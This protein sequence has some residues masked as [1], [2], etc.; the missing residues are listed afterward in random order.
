MR[1]II[2]L[3]FISLDGV[4]QAPGG[5]EEDPSD[6]FKHG[7]WTV[8]YFDEALGNVMGEQMTGPFA[9]LLGRKTFDIFASYWPEHADDWPGV[10]EATKYVVSNTLREPNWSNSVVIN[11]DI[12]AYHA[13]FLADPAMRARYTPGVRARFEATPPATLADYVPARSRMIVARKTIHEAFADVDLCIAP[14]VA[15]P[16]HTIDAALNDPPPPCE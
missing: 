8:P 13:A 12:V 14:T 5:P 10:N 7:G 2:V 4:M 9:L 11:G 1:N 16:A 3:S 15:M 6:G